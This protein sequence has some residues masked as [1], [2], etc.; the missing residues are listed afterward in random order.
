MA[1][2]K[3]LES[4]ADYLSR[5][6]APFKDNVVTDGETIADNSV[7][8][9]DAYSAL[10]INDSSS[11][12]KGTVI[13]D[14][15][16][17]KAGDKIDISAEFMNISGVKG[18]LAVD[19]VGGAG[20]AI[21]S[22]KETGYFEDLTVS[23]IVKKDGYYQV[24]AGVFTGDIGDFYIRNL[25]VTT[26]TDNTDVTKPELAINT[27]E[28][29]KVVS[30]GVFEANSITDILIPAQPFAG[31]IGISLVS[32][33]GGSQAIGKMSKKF[34]LLISDTG[35]LLG[36]DSYY[37]YSAKFISNV[38]YIG[39]ITYD[40][41]AK[42]YK[43]PLYNAG[44]SNKLTVIM[45]ATS[46]DTNAHKLVESV[47]LSASR[48]SSGPEPMPT[49]K[50][51]SPLNSTFYGKGSPEGVVTANQGSSYFNQD[52]GAGITFYVKETGTG[53]TGWVAK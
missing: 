1:R 17:L 41:T 19:I 29:R 3:R 20:V 25:T 46:V 12:H 9:N 15:G 33:Y 32:E 2:T 45:S 21:Y 28:Y 34:N 6:L 30:R 37:E 50:A 42:K 39:D 23:V 40:S 5:L 24:L 16:F 47:T 49:V 51:T 44:G 52:G 35:A 27:N 26:P 22:T 13:M 43:I 7:A 18:K 48:S 31:E 53:K 38:F 11:S 36:L 10:R 14:T 8:Y 4:K